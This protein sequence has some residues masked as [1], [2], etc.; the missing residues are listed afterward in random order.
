MKTVLD[1]LREDLDEAIK[2]RKEAL[3]LGA[4]N[5]Y[6]DYRQLVGVITGLT[7]ALDRLKDLQKYDEEM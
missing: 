1:V 7:S 5:D 2:A 4:V 3:A 6:A